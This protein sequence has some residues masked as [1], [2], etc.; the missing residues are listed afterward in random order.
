MENVVGIITVGVNILIGTATIIA[1]IV[2]SS[3]AIA[4]NKGIAVAQSAIK[5]LSSII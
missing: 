5:K 4:T 3:R 1:N 2:I